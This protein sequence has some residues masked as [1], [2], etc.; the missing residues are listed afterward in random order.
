MCCGTARREERAHK[1]GDKSPTKFITDDK[2][3][4]TKD[5]VLFSLGVIQPS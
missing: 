3:E 4:E 5:M 1:I 2:A